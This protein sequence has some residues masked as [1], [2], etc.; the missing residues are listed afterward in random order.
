MRDGS[1][2]VEVVVPDGAEVVLAVELEDG[3]RRDVPLAGPVVA[4]TAGAVRRAVPLG[5]LP[6]GWHAPARRRR[7]AR[8]HRRGR[9]GAARR[10]LP[11]ERSWGWMVQLYS[12]RSERSWGIGDYGDLRTVLDASAADGAGVVLLNPLHAETPVR[13]P[14]RRWT[15]RRAGASAHRCTCTSRTSPSTPRRPPTSGRRWRRSSR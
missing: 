4:R 15:R 1:G 7:R 13:P 6:L 9:L 2:T 14:T 10:T 3:S 12:L 5:D 11:H 8:R